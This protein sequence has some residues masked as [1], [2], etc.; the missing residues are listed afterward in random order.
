MTGV[1]RRWL[2][3]LA[4]SA[5][6][7]GLL[8]SLWAL[9]AP[10]V[11]CRAEALDTWQFQLQVTGTDLVLLQCGA[12]PWTL[13]LRLVGLGVGLVVLGGVVALLLRD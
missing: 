11:G 7:V 3:E 5:L 9:F 13:D 6:F 8:V 4:T 1:A 12:A 2:P 10:G